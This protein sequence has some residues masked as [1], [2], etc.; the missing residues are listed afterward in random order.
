[1]V[2]GTIHVD[3]GVGRMVKYVKCFLVRA[4]GHMHGKIDVLFVGTKQVID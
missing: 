1:M 3:A 4:L 2:S